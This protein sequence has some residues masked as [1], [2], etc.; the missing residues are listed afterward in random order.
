MNYKEIPAFCI[1]LDRRPDRW[2]KAQEEFKKI[3]WPVTRWSATQYTKSPY[4]D[5]P[6]GAAG[7]LD[8][9]RSIWKECVNR[10]L[11]MVAVFEDDAVFPSDFAEIFPKAVAELPSDWQFWQFHSSG[12]KQSQ[13][14]LPIGMYITKLTT[15]GWGTHGY[16]IKKSCVKVLDEFRPQIPQKVDTVLTLGLISMKVQ[17]Y[18]VRP[19]H[20]LCFQRG[21]DTDIQETA[22]TGYWSKQLKLYI[23]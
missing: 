22:Q 2:A 18:G 13:N 16:I 5:M 11:Q 21:E 10:D 14:C 15:H 23:R 17:P 7:C 1:N 9:H 12:L 3:G 8:S 4:G 20:T 6:V 19:E